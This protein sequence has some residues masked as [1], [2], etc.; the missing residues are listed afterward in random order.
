[1]C[2]LRSL[3]SLSVW[4]DKSLLVSCL[5][6]SQLSVPNVPRPELSVVLSDLLPVFLGETWR[7][8]TRL[9]LCCFDFWFLGSLGSYRLFRF[10]RD[11]QFVYL[12][13]LVFSEICCHWSSMQPSCELEFCFLWLQPL[14]SKFLNQSCL[15]DL[16]DF[17]S[18]LLRQT[19]T[20]IFCFGMSSTVLGLSPG[21]FLPIFSLK[22][23][24]SG[25]IRAF[26]T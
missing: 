4:A 16:S 25:L 9:F 10:C 20:L 19:E 13:G 11:L 14:F 5:S 3:F 8:G 12:S 24:S 22:T 18:V 1:M 21:Q 23:F 6:W 26:L 7:L 17:M 15:L 2:F